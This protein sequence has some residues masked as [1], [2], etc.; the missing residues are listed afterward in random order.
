MT[1]LKAL[2]KT[3]EELGLDLQAIA[4]EHDKYCLNSSSEDDAMNWLRSMPIE[5]LRDSLNRDSQRPRERYSLH[6]MK[7]KFALRKLHEKKKVEYETLQ[8]KLIITKIDTLITKIN[9]L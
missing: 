4:E 8:S 2:S 9:S 6:D 3:V 5:N 1:N 7:H